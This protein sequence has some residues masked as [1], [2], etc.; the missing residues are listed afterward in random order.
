MSEKLDKVIIELAEYLLE[1]GINDGFRSLA[2]EKSKSISIADLPE[3]KSRLYRPPKQSSKYSMRKH[4]L[5]G[6]I[7]TCQFAVFELIFNLG[8]EALPFIREIAWGEY[9][10]TQG[11]AIELLIRLASDDIRRDE[12]I[13]EIKYN[14]PTIREEAQLYAIQPLMKELSRND[15]LKSVF[16]ELLTVE[17]FKKSYDDLNVTG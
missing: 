10:W 7:S 15:K 2:K 6:W 17:E 11:N 5:G 4:G 3:M 14:Y 9:D 16:N 12:I 1:E 13:N 8:E